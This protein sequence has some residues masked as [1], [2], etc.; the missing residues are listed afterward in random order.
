MAISGAGAYG[1]MINNGLA[2]GA[3]QA[4]AT[5]TVA[6]ATAAT[7]RV[8]NGNSNPDVIV[9]LS[10]SALAA[11]RAQRNADAGEHAA[12]FPVR[13]GFDA[14]A[15]AAA[16]G[17]PGAT[18]SSA[19]MSFAAVAADAR[20]RMDQKYAAMAAS[21]RPFDPAS[22]EGADGHA[23]MGDLDRRSLYAVASNEGELFSAREQTLA[24]TI[25]NRQLGLAM[26]LGGGSGGDPFAGDTGAR[27]AAAQA[28]LAD[29][30][31]EEKR[32]AE[33]LRQNALV[34]SV[35]SMNGGAAAAQPTNL[36]GI[37]AEMEKQQ[38]RGGTLFDLGT[39]NYAQLANFAR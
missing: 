30:S 10:N 13:A 33:W 2:G 19:G 17:D 18:G 37:L 39:A 22:A 1:A 16:V 32:S 36:F 11:L 6:A 34:S 4:G 15:L 24:K 28:F 5:S 23:L 27:F 20:A 35:A 25:M 9:S 29:A 21:G 31:A 3:G 8:A 7:K 38:G 26:G 14:A 12:H